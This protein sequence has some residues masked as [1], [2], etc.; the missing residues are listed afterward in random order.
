MR[1]ES[2][3]KGQRKN[4]RDKEKERQEGGKGRDLCNDTIL[5]F[6]GSIC[7]SDCEPPSP[8]KSRLPIG[9]RPPKKDRPFEINSPMLETNGMD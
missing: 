5:L 2:E 9:P 8:P 1:K 3:I 4:K 7:I 6:V